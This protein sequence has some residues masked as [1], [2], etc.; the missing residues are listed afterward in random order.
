MDGI[1]LKSRI[2]PNV[3][4]TDKRI[5]EFSNRQI[6]SAEDLEVLLEK[7]KYKFW[8]QKLCRL[9][10]FKIILAMLNEWTENIP[11]KKLPDNQAV[12][13]LAR[14]L[15]KKV[16]SL[17]DIGIK[18]QLQLH[19]VLVSVQQ[20]KNTDLLSDR[21]KKAI[22]FFTSELTEKIMTPVKEHIQS[23]QYNSRVNRYK[24]FLH[25]LELTLWQSVQKLLGATYGEIVFADRSAFSQFSPG[26]LAKT[27]RKKREPKGSSIRMTSELFNA[28]KSIEEI[29]EIRQM[30]V[31]TIQ[32]H[33]A[34]MVSTGEIQAT[35]LMPLDKIHS[36][37]SVMN[38]EGMNSLG[39]I[40]SRMGNDY[41]FFEIR[42]VYS[43]AQYLNKQTA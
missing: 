26:E 43:Q 35:D 42:V 13:L 36:I 32:T 12:I 1:I 2:P 5:V 17:N 14:D 9:F 7:E 30:A 3:V 11:E 19:Q 29:A 22:G 34:H 28:G 31:S 40:K 24:S 21:M 18:F 25:D 39:M 37:Q 41:S 8:G 16:R 33:L 10:E 4:S 23:L 15:M 6:R 38:E 20:N 27:K